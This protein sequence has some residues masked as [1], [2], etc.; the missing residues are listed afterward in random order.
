MGLPRALS[1]T[2]TLTLTN[3]TLSLAAGTTSTM[4]A[5]ATSGANQK[6]LLSTVF[7]SQATISAS[8]GTVTVSNLTIQDSNA[9]GGAVWLAPFANNNVYGG[10]NTGWLFGTQ[11]SRAVVEAATQTDSPACGNSIQMSVTESSNITDANSSAFL[12]NLI[13]NAQSPGWQDIETL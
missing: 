13:D 1:V 5:F 11:Y 7:G 12:W 8:S 6:L 2:G 3:G 4:A 9:I 10:N